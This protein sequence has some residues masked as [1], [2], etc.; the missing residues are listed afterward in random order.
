MH[1][2]DSFKKCVNVVPVIKRFHVKLQNILDLK[3]SFYR[4]AII[5][6]IGN[7]SRIITNTLL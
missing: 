1:T 2:F 7:K 4:N 3:K 6:L 5:F